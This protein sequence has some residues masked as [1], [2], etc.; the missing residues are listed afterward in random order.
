VRRYR[1][2]PCGQDALIVPAVLSAERVF[3]EEIKY[4][5]ISPCFIQNDKEVLK[6]TPVK[7]IFNTPV[8]I[9][10]ES[11]KIGF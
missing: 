7:K 3:S 5:K 1:C 10:L 4:A 6:V 9:L 8:Q 11:V 2:F